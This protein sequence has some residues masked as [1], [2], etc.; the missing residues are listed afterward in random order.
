LTNDQVKTEIE[1]VL[2]NAFGQHQSVYSRSDYNP[3]DIHV[4]RWSQD[5]RFYG[6]YS[7]FPSSSLKT[8]EEYNNF[9]KKVTSGQNG[10]DGAPCIYFAGEA[11]HK[12]YKGYTHGAYYTGEDT[13]K[14]IIKDF[15][16]Y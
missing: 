3:A 8:E 1:N 13:A 6:S 15:N 2:W 4:P 9:Y 10:T 11:F 14:E 7:S 5:Q 16:N 12:H